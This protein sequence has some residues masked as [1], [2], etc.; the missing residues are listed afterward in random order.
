MRRV[1]WEIFRV[2]RVIGMRLLIVSPNYPPQQGGV[3]TYSY[4]LSVHLRPLVNKL[5]I[6]APWQ[7]DAHVVDKVLDFSVHR[8]PTIGDNFAFSGILPV[9]AI[10]TKGKYDAIFC[11]HWSA[12]YPALLAQRI[13]VTR[14][15]FVGV[16]G[17]EVSLRPFAKHAVL[18]R[19]YDEIRRRVFLGATR[20]FP[21]SHY[22]A[23]LLEKAGV[24]PKRI[25][26]VPNGVN[27]SHFF[28]EDVHSSRKMLGLSQNHRIVL[29]VARLVARKGIDTT[30]RALALLK[31]RHADFIYVIV[32]RGPDQHRLET[33]VINLGLQ[34]Q[35]LFRPGVADGEELRAYY[36]ACDIFVM[37]ARS[38][39]PDVEG[40]GLVFLEASACAKPVIAARAGG[41]VDAVQDE[42]TGFL[43]D[44][45][46]DVPA[47][48]AK[49]NQLMLD[50][51]LC[52]QLGAAGFAWVTN[53]MTWR[54]TALSLYREM[55]GCLKR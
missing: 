17:K 45:P 33:M 40:F 12:A 8:I 49:L 46:D 38:E 24:D 42:V 7:K 20:L 44:P 36:N 13:G 3:Q 34:G 53:H 25:Q 16:H 23:A 5:A 39:V 50:D 41:V 52:R 2:L 14:N 29:T 11:S 51:A 4:E 19:R 32:G 55:V 15:L 18:Q 9:A 1:G 26:V 43:I 48:A 47:L 10:A 54:H 28:S 35:V 22:S 6:V 30:L 31:Q 27:L 37:P 21:V